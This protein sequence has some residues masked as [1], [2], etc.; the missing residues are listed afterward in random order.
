MFLKNLNNITRNYYSNIQLVKSIDNNFHKAS[1]FVLV[2]IT[3]T[4][5]KQYYKAYLLQTKII[6]L[7]WYFHH[8]WWGGLIFDTLSKTLFHPPKYVMYLFIFWTY[9]CSYN[10]I[11]MPKPDNLKKKKNQGAHCVWK[12]QM[13]KPLSPKPTNPPTDLTQHIIFLICQ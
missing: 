6:C 3:F 9:P 11:L 1:N 5:H 10:H 2:L 12:P 4:K 7:Q 8:T 13:T